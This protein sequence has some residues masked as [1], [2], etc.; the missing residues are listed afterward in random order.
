[1]GKEHKK[2]SEVEILLGTFLFL[3]C[4]GICFL[5]DWTGVGI[6]VSRVIKWAANGAMMYVAWQKG[7]TNALKSGRVIGKFA[8]NTVPFLPTLTTIF[9]IETYLHNHPKIAG[10]AG[11]A[12][13]K[14][15]S[16]T[17]TKDIASSAKQ[18]GIPAPIK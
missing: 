15:A 4:D 13:G 11:A 10:T 6:I 1:M 12:A 3:G 18:L 2:Y 5:I 7:D 8:V 14:P 9:W 16:I 17:K